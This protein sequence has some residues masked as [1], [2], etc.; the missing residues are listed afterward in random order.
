MVNRLDMDSSALQDPHESEDA[1]S[2]PVNEINNECSDAS[3]ELNNQ[4]LNGRT[5][6]SK[7]HSEER[8]SDSVSEN[9]ASPSNTSHGVLEKKNKIAMTSVNDKLH[10]SPK[11]QLI[12]P[13]DISTTGLPSDYSDCREIPA[14]G[15]ETACSDPDTAKNLVEPVSDRKCHALTDMDCDSSDL[16]RNPVLDSQVA[17]NTLSFKEVDMNDAHDEV[18]EAGPLVNLSQENI[19]RE[20]NEN[21]DISGS[22]LNRV[23]E[24]S[25]QVRSDR[26]GENEHERE[27]NLH[28]GT[29]VASN[30]MRFDET[31]LNASGD[32]S[33]TDPA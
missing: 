4:V 18:L 20:N 23:S 22:V 10:P 13:N 33:E 2:N 1:N 12:S 17:D 26:N 11:C 24:N 19:A 15:Q 9:C 27:N 14:L 21:V 28:L 8:L 31:D 25:L 3:Q 16:D 5:V 32:S 6:C 29:E 7:S 30:E